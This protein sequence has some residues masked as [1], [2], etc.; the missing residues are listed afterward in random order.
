MFWL[1]KKRESGWWLCLWYGD[2]N[3]RCDIGGGDDN[4]NSDNGRGDEQQKVSLSNVKNTCFF[5][6]S[7][8]FETILKPFQ[9]YFY[10]MHFILKITFKI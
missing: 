7:I 9:L 4:D 2:S 1:S 6:K 5:K 8:G 10:Q 3:D